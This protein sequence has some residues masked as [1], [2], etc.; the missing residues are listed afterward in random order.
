MIAWGAWFFLAL[1]FFL[2]DG[3]LAAHALPGL[4]LTLAFCLYLALFARSRALPGLLVM[5]GLARSVVLDGDAALHVL[6]LGVPV[7]VLV[8][9][10]VFF[11]RH[12]LAWQGLASAFLALTEPHMTALLAHLSEQPAP[13]DSPT[14]VLS[15]LAAA[16]L[17]PAATWLLRQLPPLRGF[18]ERSD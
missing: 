9:L 4:D 17:V 14:T 8:P 1:P 6:A 10:R 11:S 12:H 18:V 7:A 3:W 13:D 15:I 2:L 16:A 5:A